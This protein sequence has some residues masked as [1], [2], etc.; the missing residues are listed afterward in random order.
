MNRKKILFGI[1]AVL[2]GL[3]SLGV[4]LEIL[5]RI[6]KFSVPTHGRADHYAGWRLSEG[7]YYY[8]NKEG[9]SEG[10]INSHGLRDYEYPYRKS[11]NTCR[12]LVFGD[13]FTEALQVDLDSTF[14]KILE[15][16]LNERPPE[17]GVKY[18]VL[19]M[20]VSGYGTANSYFLYTSEGIKYSPD[21]VILA[22]LTA[23][24]IRNNSKKLD[25]STVRP[26]FYIN[27]EGILKED[28]SYRGTF[29]W[30][31]GLRNIFRPLK[32]K[33]YLIS[34]I[35]ERTE[36]LFKHRMDNVAA[37]QRKGDLP[38]SRDW[39]IYLKELP[40][41]WNEA[42]EISKRAILKFNNK[43]RSNGSHFLLL[44]LTNG[45]Q[46]SDKL[47]PNLD[48]ALGKGN[49]DLEKP[50]RE[51]RLFAEQNNIDL[52]QL[53]P[54]FKESY[55]KTGTYYHGFAGNNSEG[56]DGHWNY[57]GHRLAGELLYQFLTGY[58]ARNGCVGKGDPDSFV[59]S[60]SPR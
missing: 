58:F 45:S 57:K 12:I 17:A 30:M 16:K 32:H 6:T 7:A 50:D 22:F 31:S 41:D 10:Y 55:L 23:N 39:T 52:F 15:R 48:M 40:P 28:L 51:I 14:V 49:Y 25:K 54:S 36:L 1:I 13:S 27:S 8:N 11:D 2:I 5:L 24:D 60:G 3:I 9:K 43:V 44:T 26:Y 37:L 29:T 20:G 56:Y 19:N 33:S 21:L 35:V 4:I 34:L 38:S 59:Q 53:L 47:I 42:Y 46:I 18:E